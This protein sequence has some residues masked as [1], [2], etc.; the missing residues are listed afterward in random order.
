M[1]NNTRLVHLFLLVLLSSLPLL[2]GRIEK[3]NIEI[4]LK[5]EI[6][7]LLVKDTLKLGETAENRE[8][9]FL[10]NK[11][12]NLQKVLFADRPIRW[13]T[14]TMPTLLPD[15]ILSQE[16]SRLAEY[17]LQL[18][19]EPKRGEVVLHY[20]ISAHDSIRNAAFSREYIA[21]EV[22][23]YIGKE[24]AFFSPASGWY[25]QI[26]GEL[27]R[28]ELKAKLPDSLRLI[29]QG[30][31]ISDSV[32]TG[33]RQT[34]WEIN[35]P[36]TDLHLV[37]APFVVT[38]KIYKDIRVQTWFFKGSEDLS[39]KYLDAS[40]RYLAMYENQIGPYPFSKFAVV[41][42]FFPTGYGMPSYTLLG[43]QVLRL[44]FIIY[45]SLGHE[46]A[47]NWWGNSVYVN[48]QSGNWCEGLTTYFADYS[49]K[50]ANSEEDAIDYR[51]NICRDFSVY[52]K[53]EKDFPLSKFTSRT[54]NAS[55]AIGYGK[56][57]MVFHQLRKLLGDSL[58]QSAMVK[59]YKENRFHFAGWK[60]I[61][62]AAEA[63]SGKQLD[64]YFDQWIN[65]PGA[66]KLLLHSV[67]FADG[68]LSFRL[69]QKEP[70]YKL[71][72]PVEISTA[73]QQIDTLIWF[74]APE[75]EFILSLN[76]PPKVV[77][78]DPKYE[79]LRLLERS[80]TPPTLSEI[81]AADSVWL[82][83]PDLCEEEK[84]Q[85]YHRFAEQYAEGEK[86]L[87]IVY[88]DDLTGSGI[89]KDVSI[90]LMGTLQENSAFRYV[91]FQI[92]ES[93]KL[94]SNQF[95]LNNVPLPQPDDLTVLMFRKKENPEQSVCI[96]ALGQNKQTGRVAVLLKHYGKYSYLNFR[97]GRNIEK[98]V[99]PVTTSPL[100]YYFN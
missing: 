19:Q 59:F 55:R 30:K 68:K 45:T 69:K 91:P 77:K 4:E 3:Q 9:K 25:P 46:I 90:I 33:Q 44:P 98:G 38:T 54:E 52:V 73:G 72:L 65:R 5:P 86:N 29:T 67:A 97:N 22:K 12:A 2:A 92:P 39:E 85:N 80:E 24:G 71:L 50:E 23:A 27:S 26:P 53:G 63:V 61:Q 13:K 11:Q 64:W 36:A 28:F 31:L 82:I 89:P 42:N 74:D 87:K 88:A 37:A 21:Y 51:R 17:I 95:V 41:E 81:F 15:S 10:L 49:Y 48:Y 66:P 20:Q 99:H 14:A 43:S 58:F 8:L 18:P 1:K 79:V 7:T 57:A 84:Q 94:E 100:F 32:T 93:V 78:I 70:H 56:S 6:K 76:E 60:D 96:I 40:V 83:L 34:Y 35:Y 47:H 62:A 16:N 75:K